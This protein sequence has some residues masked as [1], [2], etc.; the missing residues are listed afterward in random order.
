MDCIV[1]GVAK[2]QT[3]LSNFH[4]HTDTHTHIYIYNGILFSNKKNEIMSFVATW[5]NLEIMILS[6]ISQEE[7]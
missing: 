5:M 7:R 4:C 2:S 3:Q 6:G 1:H